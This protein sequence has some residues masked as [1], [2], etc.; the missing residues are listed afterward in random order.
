MARFQVDLPATVT[1]DYPT[2]TTLSKFIASKVSPAAASMP[3]SI[4][5]KGATLVAPAA[6]AGQAG[7]V[8]EIVGI[9][10]SVAASGTKDKGALKFTPFL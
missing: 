1:F 2:I 7:P 9:S 5:Q 3:L 6:L 10:S 8:T 4:S